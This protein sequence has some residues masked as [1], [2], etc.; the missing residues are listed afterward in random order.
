METVSH[1]WLV[2]EGAPFGD[3]LRLVCLRCLSVHI[4]KLP[5][6]VYE[7]LRIAKAFRDLHGYCREGC[8]PSGELRPHT[9]SVAP[10]DGVPQGDAR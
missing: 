7:L 9:G 2:V 3:P 1:P 8:S 4:V 5:V 10:G 6:N